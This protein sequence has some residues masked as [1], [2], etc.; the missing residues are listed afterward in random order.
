MFFLFNINNISVFSFRIPSLELELVV[1][2]RFIYAHL[3]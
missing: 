3:I 2:K 1:F